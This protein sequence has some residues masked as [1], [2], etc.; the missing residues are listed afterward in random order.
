M[1]S[2]AERAIAIVG[3]GAILPDAPDTAAFW[4][5]VSG[6]RYSISE[7]DPARWDPALFYDRDP[8]APDKLYST[9]GGWVRD[10]DWSPLQWRLPIPP[11]VGEVMDEAQKWA[12]AGTRAAL[13]DYGW[14]GRTFDT[15]RTA[16]ILGNAMSGEQH[17][18]TYLRVVY[19]EIARELSR[20]PA[21]SALPAAVQADVIAQ[22]HRNLDGMLPPV[23]E[24]TMP[25]ELGNCMAGRVANLF[26][27]HG[28]NYVSTRPARPR[29]PRSTRPSKVWRRASSTRSSPVGSTGTW[30]RPAS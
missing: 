20:A 27:L 25:G 17:Y 14:P 19:P 10:W 21:F 23:T 8:K 16:V 11:R 9:I 26:D 12:V 6:G 13:L 1:S 24:D 18:Q 29:W 5:N 30:A 4:A 22:T 3:V 7:V 2:S 28:P 15:E